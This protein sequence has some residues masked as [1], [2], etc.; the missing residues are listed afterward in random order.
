M[1][2]PER[3]WVDEWLRSI[4]AE[5]GATGEKGEAYVA[6]AHEFYRALLRRPVPALR[7]ASGMP[8]PSATTRVV[9]KWFH[10]GLS[11]M[12]LWHVSSAIRSCLVTNPGTT[13][14]AEP[15]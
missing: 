5:T 10:R 8:V 3:G 7:L 4:V 9:W 14:E 1:S 2:V 6:F 15:A 12:R 13:N 11:A